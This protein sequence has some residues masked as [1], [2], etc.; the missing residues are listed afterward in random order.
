MASHQFVQVV[1][2]RQSLK[3]GCPEEIV[4][5]QGRISDEQLLKL[6]KPLKKS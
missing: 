5:R 2:E 3:I 4:W 1:E 6:A